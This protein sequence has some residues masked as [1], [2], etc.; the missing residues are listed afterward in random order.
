MNAS[1][2]QGDYVRS[3]YG[4]TGFNIFAGIERCGEGE[5]K[6][7][8]VQIRAGFKINFTSMIEK[9]PNRRTKRSTTKTFRS[10]EK[11][12][13]GTTSS[14]GTNRGC[15]CSCFCQAKPPSS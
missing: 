1:Q 14:A 7:Q 10:H 8:S 11:K 9:R 13:T 5:N 12:F 15:F 3:M 4:T 2:V 6:T